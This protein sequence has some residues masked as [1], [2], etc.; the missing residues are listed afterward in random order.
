MKTKEVF[1]CLY[2]VW[3]DGVHWDYGRWYGR[4]SVQ[5]RVRKGPTCDTF[6]LDTMRQT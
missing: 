1:V 5:K 4:G 6:Y 3:I 2:G